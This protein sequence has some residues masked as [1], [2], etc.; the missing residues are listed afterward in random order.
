MCIYH[1]VISEVTDLD[2]FD[3]RKNSSPMS[4]ITDL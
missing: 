3:P 4:G 2:A 1:F